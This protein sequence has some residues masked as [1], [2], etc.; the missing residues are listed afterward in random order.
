MCISNVT[1]IKNIQNIQVMANQNKT[2]IG[3]IGLAVMGENLALNMESKGWNGLR[4]LF[5]RIT[6]AHC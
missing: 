1:K 3:L 4:V 2:D 6:L 5:S